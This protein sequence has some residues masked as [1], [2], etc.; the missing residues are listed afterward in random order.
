[1]CRHLVTLGL[2]LIVSVQ[3]FAQKTKAVQGTFEYAYS[4]DMSPAVAIE[5]SK[6]KTRT[7]LIEEAFGC[8]YIGTNII[9][10]QSTKGVASH[11]LA[12]VQEKRLLGIW[13]KDLA[14]PEVMMT[15]DTDQNKMNVSISL[16]CLIQEIKSEANALQVTLHRSGEFWDVVS[17]GSDF[18]SNDTLSLCVNSPGD[19][20]IS[21]YLIDEDDMAECL[22]PYSHGPKSAVPISG[23]Q[24]HQLFKRKDPRDRDV[25]VY[26]LVNSSG[27]PVRMTLDILFSPRPFE[28]APVSEKREDC[29]D[30]LSKAEYYNWRAKFLSKSCENLSVL[31]PIIVKP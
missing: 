6:D 22:L 16:K 1:M 21:V 30:M 5:D 26:K 12:S 3:G 13:L 20:Y 14:E 29:P 28:K 7:S 17:D 2:A 25:D 4:L 8:Y 31:K 10:I 23:G 9:T 19:G 11:E 27:Q 24:D 15:I 18:R